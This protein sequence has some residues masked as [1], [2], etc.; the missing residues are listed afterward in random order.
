MLARFT[1][2]DYDRE[3]AFVA[4]VGEAPET[5]IAV[6]R[7]VANLDG[8]S[9]E[10]AIVIADEWQRKG[11]GRRMM[12][13]LIDV[14]RSKGLREMMGHVLAH[15]HGMLALCA[16]LGFSIADSAADPGV[17]RVALAL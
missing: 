12:G 3:M 9:C 11:L 15:N 17:K 2:I 4:T 13:A 16:E 7:Y 8:D 10:F 1:Q 14:A 6:C 5:E